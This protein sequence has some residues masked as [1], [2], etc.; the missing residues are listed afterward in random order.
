[1]MTRVGKKPYF[2]DIQSLVNKQDGI[3]LMTSAIIHTKEDWQSQVT[4]FVPDALAV[5]RRNVPQVG[6]LRFMGLVTL[7]SQRPVQPCLDL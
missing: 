5:S 2:A 7:C 3:L 4:H 1:M 6:R